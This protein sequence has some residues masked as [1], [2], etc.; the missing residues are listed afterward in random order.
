[1]TNGD[2]L[3]EITR[4][5]KM[6]KRTEIKESKGYA[7]LMKDL[8]QTAEKG[9]SYARILSV[10]VMSL[11]EEDGVTFTELQGALETD[12]ITL[13]ATYDSGTDVSY[14]IFKFSW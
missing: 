11:F 14:A 10:D 2:R 5:A 4:Q 3:R 7:L 8:E 13:K 12:G 1:M 9:R 6:N